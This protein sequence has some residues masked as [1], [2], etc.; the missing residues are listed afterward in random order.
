MLLSL[1][2]SLSLQY[3]L[4]PHVAAVVNA[5]ETEDRVVT[6]GGGGEG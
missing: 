4:I 5:G 2:R 1:A 3:H 6:S